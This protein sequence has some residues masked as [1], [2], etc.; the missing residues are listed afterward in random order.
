[1]RWSIGRLAVIFCPIS[2]CCAAELET[3]QSSMGSAQLPANDDFIRRSLLSVAVLDDYLYIDGGEVSSDLDNSRSTA[4]SLTLSIP[5]DE[6]WTNDTVAFTE[7]AK[8]PSP[9]LKQP[10]LWVD[11][12]RSMIYSWGGQGSY[13]NTSAAGDHH[14]YAFEADD[15]KGRWSIHDPDDDTLFSSLYR[16]VRGAYTTCHGVGYHLGGYGERR[17]DERFTDGSYVERPLDGLLTYNITTQK[18]TNESTKALDYVT[19]S[20]RA[21]CIPSISS[22][23]LLI[24]MGGAKVKTPSFRNESEPVSFTNITI[25]DPSSKEWYYQ[26]TSGV[27]PDPRVDFCSVGVQGRNN[28]YEIYIYGC[29]NT[30]NDKTKAFGDVWVLSLP[31]FKW[32]KAEV[33]GPKRGMHG[34]A[35][36]G[37]RQMLSIGGNNW[38]KNE[39]WKDKDPWTQGIGILDLPS[40]TWSSEYD[41]EAADYESPKVVKDWYQSDDEVEWDNREVAK[42]FASMSTTT[43]RSTDGPKFDSPPD[44]S[45][46]TPVGAIAGGVVGGVAAIV[47]LVGIWLWIRRRKRN[48]SNE[49]QQNG[50]GDA[51]KQCGKSELPA[52]SSKQNGLQELESNQAPTEL[53]TSSS[54]ILENKRTERHELEA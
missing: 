17:T 7:S 2:L 54:P 23:G 13:K 10:A 25:Y 22:S 8:G 50:D 39:G 43:T 35:L 12:E 3:R 28:T 53:P 36:V 16:S 45:S 19:W 24:F 38:G 4:V 14:L 29:W 9:Y 48:G 30:W 33:D 18:W 6:S 11:E 40:L 44:N 20:G 27:S 21:T 49:V 1:M 47:A 15:G 31:A 51:T 52:D 37:K 42:L 34:C 46:S 26:Q 5:L 41:A 32:F